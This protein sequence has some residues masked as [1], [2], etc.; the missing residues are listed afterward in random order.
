M[1]IERKETVVDEL[2]S[3]RDWVR[4]GASQFNANE[5][6]FGHGTDNA[7]DEALHLALHVLSLPWDL[8]EQIW[9]SRITRD[10]RKRIL[11]LYEQ[12]IHERI[13]AAYLIGR[14]WFAGMPFIVNDC[15]L[16]PRS[17]IAEMIEQ[18]FQ[19]WLTRSP[20]RILDLCT[21]SGC[22]GLACAAH[23]PSAE[24]DLS[25][26]SI[27]ALDI[28]WQNIA[29]HNEEGRVRA[30]ESDGLSGLNGQT[31]DLIVTNP[32]YVD[33][34]DFSSMPPE[35]HHEPSLGLVSGDDGLDFT[36][37]LLIEAP[38]YLSSDGLLVCEVGNS[39]IALEAAFPD[40][41]FTWVEFQRG[42][43]GV[44]VL[45]AEQLKTYQSEF[46]NSLS[47]SD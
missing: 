22:I 43:H 47:A 10:E 23:F 44:F 37:R 21:G 31:Y 30:L 11:A 14:A 24:V 7:W 15:V 33:Q 38:N 2:I 18:S 20:Q 1:M 45:T 25:D 5:L 46:L 17:P 8:S 4:W 16:V 13:P 19:P 3:L 29:L 36:R 34:D 35:Y 28:A 26:I 9:E 12:R 6:F 27:E 32:P 42:G 41:P 39:W 40:V